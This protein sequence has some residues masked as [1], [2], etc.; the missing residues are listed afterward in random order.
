M[1]RQLSYFIQPLV[2]IL[3]IFSFAC[4]SNTATEEN[5]E[6]TPSLEDEVMAIHDE[7][8]AKMDAMHS[9]ESSIKTYL[10]GVDSTSAQTELEE[11]T[12]KVK[13]LADA[14]EAM[15]NWMRN[16]EPPSKETPEEEVKNYLTN[17]K[18]TMEE[19]AKMIDDSLEE[20]KA[21]LEGKQ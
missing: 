17:Q 3:F 6:K 21:F 7:A 1:K 18:A 11:G 13:A 2:A 10:S 5:T 15:M 8:M 14:S 19:V 20:G 4:S 12:A 9:M 16:Y